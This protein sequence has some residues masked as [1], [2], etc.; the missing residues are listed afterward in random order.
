MSS[1][2][3]TADALSSELRPWR[4]VGWR[5][6]EA[7]HRVAT[8][9]LVDTLEEQELLERLIEE[10]EPPVPEP[11]R[12]LHW[13]LSTPFR[14]RPSPHASRFRRAGD[15]RGVFYAAEREATA[16]AEIVFWRLL[17]FA[18]APDVPWPDRALEFTAF[19][20][21]FAT[22]RALHLMEPPFDRDR[23]L[24]THPADY[25]ACHALAEAAREVEAG[26]L[27]YES[28]RD[29]EGGIN[30]AVLRCETFAARK[31]RARSFRIWK[32][33]FAASGVR[34]MR[35]RPADAVAYGRE[36]FAG[37]PRIAAMLWER[38]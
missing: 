22:A 28:A 25:A 4:G 3:W 12:H 26:L 34:A 35:E 17:F 14:Y 16:L 31:P 21:D 27:R 15:P 1:P 37:D 38:G 11:C 2:I 10:T 33:F 9:P 24:W 19:A 8:L 30:L 23:A 7:Q 13:L 6:V 5:L 29:P 32:V 20:C 36:S 18:E